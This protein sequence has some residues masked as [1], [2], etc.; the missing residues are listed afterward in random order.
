[1]KILE[2]KL[3]GN[4]EPICPYCNIK[5][6]KMPA[7]KTK[8]K[9][10]DN[11]Y[12]ARTRPSDRKK[13]VLTEEQAKLVEEQWTEQRAVDEFNKDYLEVKQEFDEIKSFLT[14]QYG[15]EPRDY[16]VFWATYNRLLSNY[17]KSFKWG[18]YRNIRLKMAQLLIREK[19]TKQA[20]DTLLEICY[21]DING[22]RN[23]GKID[24]ELFKLFPPFDEKLGI[25]APGIIRMINDLLSEVSLSK[26]EIENRFI[27]I[28][29]RLFA[30]LKILP[31]K[32]KDAWIKLSIEIKEN[33]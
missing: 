20:L 28:S 18:F 26:T 4:T 3:V 31:I 2:H 6:E 13:V 32:P 25:L 29:E 15:R 9:N 30:D 24:W 8:C 14:N 27:N 33:T 16:D 11:Y 1:M 23:C 12:Y 7:R 5:L 17:A 19:R 22:P 21:I 10:C